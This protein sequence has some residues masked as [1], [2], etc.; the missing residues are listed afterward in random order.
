MFHTT[1]SNVR[2]SYKFPIEDPIISSSIALQQCTVNKFLIHMGR[3]IIKICIQ[4]NSVLSYYQI[5]F[6]FP[7][8]LYISVR[9]ELPHIVDNHSHIFNL[10]R[11]QN[12]ECKFDVKNCNFFFLSF[13]CM[14]LCEN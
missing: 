12:P 14:C 1:I 7:T 11:T 9:K 4:I 2:H 13:P 5:G 8:H 6:Y 3:S 10:I